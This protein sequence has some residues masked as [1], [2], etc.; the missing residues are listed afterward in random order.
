MDYKDLELL[1]NAYFHALLNLKH[2]GSIDRIA[3]GLEILCKSMYETKNPLLPNL[4]EKLLDQILTSLEKGDFRNVLRRSA[5]IPPAIVCLLN[6]EPVGNKARLF[7]KTL[8]KLFELVEKGKTDD[9]K[10]HSLNILK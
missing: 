10:I 6:S 1:T 8:N 7:P 2:L 5:G 3:Q 4:A 9:I